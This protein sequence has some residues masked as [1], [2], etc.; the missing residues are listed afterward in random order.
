[1]QIELIF[2][3]NCPNVDAAR[4]LLSRVLKDSGS[5][6]EWLEWNRDDPDSPDY[7]RKFGSPT[8]LVNGHDVAG[9]EPKS[10]ANCCRVY[11]HGKD[12]LKG[13]PTFEMIRDALSN[14]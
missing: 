9:L 6:C 8:I 3:S 5:S 7:A 1:M 12:G 4:D 14:S 11:D 2:E 10:D 13:V